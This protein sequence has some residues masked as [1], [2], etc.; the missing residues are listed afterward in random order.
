MEQDFLDDY[1]I[2]LS[3]LK[4]CTN[5]TAIKGDS[6]GQSTQADIGLS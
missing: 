6:I 1:E 2:D 3:S 4:Q 5:N